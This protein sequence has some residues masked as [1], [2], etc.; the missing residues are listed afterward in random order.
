M[1]LVCISLSHG[2]S[3]FQDSKSAG[4]N[5]PKVEGQTEMPKVDVSDLVTRAE[6]K[7]ETDVPESKKEDPPPLKA[8]VRANNPDPCIVVCYLS[9][10]IS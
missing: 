8:P 9:I 6:T 7:A 1:L 10:C 5:K 4:M 2:L 3:I